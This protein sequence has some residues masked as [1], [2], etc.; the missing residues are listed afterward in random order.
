MVLVFKS[1]NVLSQM[2]CSDWLNCSLSPGGGL[3]HETDGDARRLAQGCEFWILV[4][5]RVH[6]G[7]AV[8]FYAAM[9]SLRVPQRNTELRE[10]VFFNDYVL[11]SLKLIACRICVFLSGLF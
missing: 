6:L 9:V 7:K 5:L 2:L 3:P 11:I 4:L 1:T 10:V 8:I